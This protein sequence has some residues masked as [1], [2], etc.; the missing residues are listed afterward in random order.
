MNSMSA[1]SYWYAGL[2][3][4]LACKEKAN[5]ISRHITTFILGC[6]ACCCVGMEGRYPQHPKS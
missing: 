1:Y 6:W 3:A 4:A 2:V 5:S